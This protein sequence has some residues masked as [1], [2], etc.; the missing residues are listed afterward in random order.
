MDA[1]AGAQ[2]RVAIQLFD[3]FDNPRSRN[4]DVVR[5]FIGAS[6]ELETGP[7]QFD[8]NGTYVLLYSITRS[9][10]YQISLRVNDRVLPSSAFPLR[11]S[12][13]APAASSTVLLSSTSWHQTVGVQYSIVVQVRDSY[14]NP[15]S[16]TATHQLVASI[17][18]AAKQAVAVHSMDDRSGNYALH[19]L[20][21]VS[22]NYQLS[23][24]LGTETIRGSPFDFKM[25]PGP[26]HGASSQVTG[27]G[28]TS[29]IVGVPREVVVRSRDVLGNPTVREGSLAFVTLKT[30]NQ[31]V[32]VCLGSVINGSFSCTYN[33]T[34]SGE[35]TVV[36]SVDHEEHAFEVELL[37]A[38]VDITRTN[39]LRIPR[40]GIAGALQSFTVD[41]RD[42]FGNRLG[43]GGDMVDVTLSGAASLNAV[44][45]DLHTGQY[46]VEFNATR[47]GGYA[48]SVFVWQEEVPNSPFGLRVTAATA[49][50]RQTQVSGSA[51]EKHVHL[52]GASLNLTLELVDSWG[53][54]LLWG[55]ASVSVDVVG[56]EIVRA[57]VID[58]QDGTY[59]ASFVLRKVGLYMMVVRESGNLILQQQ[60]R[61][62]DPTDNL[63][64]PASRSGQKPAG[65]AESNV[66]QILRPGLPTVR[67]ASIEEQASVHKLSVEEQIAELKAQLARM[68]SERKLA[69]QRAEEAEVRVQ[70]AMTKDSHVDSA[71]GSVSGGKHRPL[72]LF[73]SHERVVAAQPI[74]QHGSK[75]DQNYKRKGTSEER[76]AWTANA[77]TE[78][79]RRL[80]ERV[81]EQLEQVAQH[82]KD[83]TIVWQM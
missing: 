1:I 53:N 39:V 14:G 10:D 9:G 80:K 44:V 67:Q 6:S 62:T 34:Q 66:Q 21:T 25:A 28:T 41:L 52:I 79:K 8:G 17:S 36:V 19:Y 27:S 24:L 65:A 26:I 51:L 76:G 50:A 5:L 23:V 11:L 18:G 55:S 64:E 56:A 46:T 61:A 63:V 60:L 37:P 45:T 74:G 20:C 71:P 43:L 58:N 31:I 73:P 57:A 33:M 16:E 32:Q 7:P 78:Q 38:D 75:D 68:E 4:D 30:A 13:A 83:G 48:I 2:Q 82:Q 49:D 42:R 15:R 40:F 47:S 12:P 29:G 54:R 22:G 69:Q 3:D 35:C 72:T 81:R 77:D 59:D 70:M